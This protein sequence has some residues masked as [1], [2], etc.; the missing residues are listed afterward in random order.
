MEA[1]RREYI[2]RYEYRLAAM[3]RELDRRGF[4]VANIRKKL[5][6]ELK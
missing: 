1:K 2:G 5:K 3:E 6:E 4:S